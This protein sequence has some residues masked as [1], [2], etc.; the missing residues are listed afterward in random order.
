[1]RIINTSLV[2]ARNNPLQEAKR[3]ILTCCHCCGV[4]VEQYPECI[5]ISNGEMGCIA[6]EMEYHVQIALD[7]GEIHAYFRRLSLSNP[8]RKPVFEIVFLRG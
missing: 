4:P 7:D 8:D 2:G 6:P 5:D 1:M 3:A